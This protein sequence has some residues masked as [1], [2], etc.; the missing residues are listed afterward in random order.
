[1]KNHQMQLQISNQSSSQLNQIRNQKNCFIPLT[2]VGENSFNRDQI[3]FEVITNII[4][5]YV[6]IN[7]SSD[8]FIITQI[9]NFN[10]LTTIKLNSE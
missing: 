3:K 1:M 5:D 7:I 6:N 10:T 4:S 2:L 8:D 9:K